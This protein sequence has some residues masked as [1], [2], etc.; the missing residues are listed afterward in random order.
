MPPMLATALPLP[1]D[2]P[3]LRGGKSARSRLPVGAVAFAALVAACT[4]FAIKNTRFESGVTVLWIV[5]G[6]L[7]GTLLLSPRSSWRWWFAAA[8][9]GQTAG[10][11]AQG[12][13]WWLTLA[14][15][16]VNLLESAI[17]ANSVR[18]RTAA[19]GQDRSIGRMARDALLATLVACAV[20]ATLA[21]PL[22]ASRVATNLPT[23]WMTWYAAHLTGMVIVATLTVCALQP[24]VGMLGRRGKRLDY[25]LSLALL[26]A[27]CGAVFWQDRYPLLFITYLPLLWVV[28]RHGL[29]GMMSGVVLLACI[30]GIAVA[31]GHGQFSLMREETPLSRILFWQVYVAAGCALAYSTAVAMARRRQLERR[32][33]ASEARYKKLAQEAERL[34]RYDTLT[35]LANRLHFDEHLAEAVARAHRTGASLMLLAFDID[36]FKSINDSLGHAAGDAVLA[37]FARRL[38]ETVYDVDL[39]ARLGGDEFVV[40]VEYTSYS[41]AGELMAT[42]ILEAMAV[43]FVIEGVVELQV[44]TSIGVGMMRPVTTGSALMAMADRALY[45][46]K[47]RGRATWH[48]LTSEDVAAPSTIAFRRSEAAA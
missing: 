11:L 1:D 10:R 26:A 45:E 39:P 2:Y 30:S 16:A 46:A 40:L 36:R 37:E 9:I 41:A 24:K 34:A 32:L 48:M 6:L 3:P 31:H 47:S 12:D 38:R 18:G 19:L 17:V 42:R 29:P 28:W 44:S 33:L 14:L 43:P 4:W 20:S 7:T 15:V 5:N 27:T 21:A 22:L 35:G 23:T 13:S 8:A 25:V